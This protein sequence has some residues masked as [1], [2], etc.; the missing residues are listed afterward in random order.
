MPSKAKH[1]DSWPSYW[2]RTH[3]ET[4]ITPVHQAVTLVHSAD[5]HT[6]YERAVKHSL[7]QYT[8]PWHS[9]TALTLILATNARWNIHY[10]STPG[11][12]TRPQ[13]WPSYWLR[14]HG[15]TFITPVHQAVTLAHSADPHTGYERTVK[16]S[17]LHYTRP[18]HSSTALTLILATNA[19]WNIHYS[20]TPGRDTRLQRWP[21]YWLRTHGETF[22]T[23]LQQAVTL[24][25]SADHI[26]GYERTVK[27]SLLHYT[28][29]WHSSTALTLILATNA[30][31]NIHY[32]STPGRD[33]RL[34]RWPS[35]WLRTHDETFITPVHQAV[36]LVHSADPHTGYEST[37]KHSL[38]STMSY[39]CTALLYRAPNNSTVEL[40]IREKYCR[41]VFVHWTGLIIQSYKTHSS[42]LS[43]LPQGS[44]SWY[45]ILFVIYIN[46]PSCPTFHGRT[47]TLV[48]ST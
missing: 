33:T 35:Y 32:S 5:P 30:R 25:H 11:R 31:W 9:S 44:V 29:P 41:S 16:H 43:G 20:S 28:R 14:T 3:G 37:M 4:F 1:P 45:H 42:V 15:E 8:R 36:T 21:S 34:Q 6:G 7:L 19:R 40:L 22:I 10:S 17:L 48:P 2:L 39:V 46:Y 13:R 38:I 23:P 12:D 18:W 26:T 24:V 47:F 27:H